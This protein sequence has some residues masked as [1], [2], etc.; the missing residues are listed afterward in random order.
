MRWARAALDLG[1]SVT[2]VSAPVSLETPVG[3][4]RVEVRTAQE[5]M[6][7]VLEHGADA[8][9]LLMAAAVADFRPQNVAE[10]K[11]KKGQ[12]S[13]EIK[14]DY[15]PDVLKEVAK[16]K[17]ESGF[18]RVTVGF[19]AESQ[20]LV[21]NAEKKLAEK[22]LEMIVAND[23]SASDAGFAVDTNRVTLL[24]AGGERQELPL[25][26]KDDVAAEVLAHVVKLL[27]PT[28]K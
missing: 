25:M 21:A 9:V 2:I 6:E 23:I 12:R 7:A 17:T 28:I 22:K 18:P 11:I 5:M 19:A 15:A 10:Q 1:A 20:D 27:E 24:F 14:L 8:D 26:S 16:R 13:P 4:L 3:A